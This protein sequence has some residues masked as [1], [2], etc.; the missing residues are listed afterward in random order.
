MV[1]FGQPQLVHHSQPLIVDFLVMRKSTNL[2]PQIFVLANELVYSP[3]KLFEVSAKDG[4]ILQS[5]FNRGGC[6]IISHKDINLDGN[7]ELLL[8]GLNDGFD[9]A[10]LVV[11]DPSSIGGSSPVP[12]IETPP[13]GTRGREMYYILFPRWGRD[14]QSGHKLY[15]VVGRLINPQGSGIDVAVDEVLMDPD[16]GQ[17]VRASLFF[18]LDSTLRAERIMAD[19]AVIRIGS[20]LY[21]QGKI[22][23]PISNDSFTSLRDSVLYWDGESF[24]NQPTMNTHYKTPL[25]PA[26]SSNPAV[27]KSSWSR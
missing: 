16:N 5:Y 21:K 24:L 15:N 10:C 1:S 19:D 17:E 14:I 27:I 11:L 13:Q 9:E 4:V 22:K 26:Q 2:K 12:P 3:S 8:G 6:T 23:G 7:E 20:V 25:T 18:G